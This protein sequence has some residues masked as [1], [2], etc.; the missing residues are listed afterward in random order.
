M[1]TNRILGTVLRGHNHCLCTLCAIHLPPDFLKASASPNPANNEKRHQVYT[2]H[3]LPN[4]LG[5][6]RDKE[7]LGKESHLCVITISA[8]VIEYIVYNNILTFLHVWYR[9]LEPVPKPQCQYWDFQV[10]V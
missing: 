4:D 7:Y 8:H 9:R 10:N 5:L 6:W 3:R 1:A 2:L